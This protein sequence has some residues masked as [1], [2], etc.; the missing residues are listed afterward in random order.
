[1]QLCY[2]LIAESGLCFGGYMV[3][4]AAGPVGTEPAS[5]RFGPFDII[6]SEDEGKAHG[7][8]T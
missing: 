4:F 2:F 3:I 8:A 7:D 1:M 6:V 5:G